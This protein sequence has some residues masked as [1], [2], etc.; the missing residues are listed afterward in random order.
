MEKPNNIEKPLSYK[1]A[2]FRGILTQVIS[3]S[4]LPISVMYLILDGITK[5]I[6]HLADTQFE[7]EKNQYINALKN[8]NETET[9]EFVEKSSSDDY[10]M[11]EDK[12]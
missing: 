5:E 7:N 9:K 3:N 2:E 1:M 10:E 12:N 4:E 8:K 6:G 11:V